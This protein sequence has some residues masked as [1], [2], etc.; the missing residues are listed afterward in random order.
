MNKRAFPQIQRRWLK[1]LDNAL[2]PEAIPVPYISIVHDRIPLKFH[3]VA[4]E[5]VVFVKRA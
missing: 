4:P 2:Y 3:G 1:D 5:V